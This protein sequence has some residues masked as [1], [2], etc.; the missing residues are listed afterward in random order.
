MTRDELKQIIDSEDETSEKITEILNRHHVEVSQARENPETE[1][2]IETLESQ[3]RDTKKQLSET[4]KNLKST[5]V[6]IQ[7]NQDL[8]SQLDAKDVEI[9]ALKAEIRQGKIDNSLGIVLA[10]AGVK[11]QK[12]ADLIKHSIDMSTV[13]FDKDGNV[14]GLEEQVEALKK[15]EDTAM[16]FRVEPD[17]NNSRQSYTPLKGT[18]RDVSEI[19]E[20]FIQERAERE[21][22]TPVEDPFLNALK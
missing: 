20:M 2:K 19:E 21:Q 4:R 10:K 6:E 11:N 9:E 22:Q 13:D 16:L 3:L 7:G 14:T 18:P 12:F 15:D 8:Q 5:E 17:K 1:R